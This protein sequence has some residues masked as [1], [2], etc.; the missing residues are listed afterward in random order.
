MRWRRKRK[1]DPDWRLSEKEKAYKRNVLEDLPPNRARQ[2][3][4]VGVLDPDMSVGDSEEERLLRLIALEAVKGPSGKESIDFVGEDW[5]T[6]PLHGW[7]VKKPKGLRR[8]LFRKRERIVWGYYEPA[9]RW[10]MIPLTFAS[11][12]IKTDEEEDVTELCYKLIIE[13]RR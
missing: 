6:I 7:V 5:V 13:W 11:W 12:A 3:I 1:L 10:A 4:V 2:G 8:T 9:D